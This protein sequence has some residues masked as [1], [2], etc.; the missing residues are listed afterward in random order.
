MF[1]Q[2]VI[3][4]CCWMLVMK[5]SAGVYRPPSRSVRILIKPIPIVISSNIVPA[6]IFLC[7]CFPAQQNKRDPVPNQRCVEGDPSQVLISGL[8]NRAT[9]PKYY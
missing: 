7:D 5:L 9:L 8:L 2:R 6:P 1:P 3:S 4:V